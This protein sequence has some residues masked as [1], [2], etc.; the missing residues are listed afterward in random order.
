MGIAFHRH[1]PTSGVLARGKKGNLMIGKMIL[2]LYN[3]GRFNNDNHLAEDFGRPCPRCAYPVY[4]NKS[5]YAVK[6]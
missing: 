1:V 3:R 4:L 2:A 6:E 5:Y